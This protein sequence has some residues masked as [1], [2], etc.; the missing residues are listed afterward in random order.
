[1]NARPY[2][3]PATFRPNRKRYTR[4]RQEVLPSLAILTILAILSGIITYCI[5]TH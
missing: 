5:L 2:F 1:M 4:L 3:R